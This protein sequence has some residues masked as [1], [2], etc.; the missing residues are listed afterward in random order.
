VKGKAYSKKGTAVI[1]GQS[2]QRDYIAGAKKINKRSSSRP[3]AA[4]RTI[5]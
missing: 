3:R 1:Y 4:S 2:S 5:E